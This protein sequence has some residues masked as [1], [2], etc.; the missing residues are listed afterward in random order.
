MQPWALQ[1]ADRFLHHI[2]TP[3][4]SK[5]LAEPCKGH[6]NTLQ[7]VAQSIVDSCPRPRSSDELDPII[8]QAYVSLVASSSS[9]ADPFQ[10]RR[11]YSDAS[12]LRCLVD[13]TSQ[14]LDEE[15]AM[16]CVAR[17]DHALIVAGAPG[18]GMQS[19]IRDLIS[20]TQAEYLP[21]E[22]F[23]Y[24]PK[25][26]VRPN[27][28]PSAPHTPILSTSSGTI[29]R[30]VDAPP[31]SVFRREVMIRPFIMTG[32][33]SDWPAMNDH[34]WH[35]IDYLRSVA[36]RGRVIPVEIGKDYRTDDWTQR[37]MPWDDFLDSLEKDTTH[38]QTILYMAQH[39][40]LSQFC[41]LRE[42]IVVPDYV[43]TA[44]QAPATYPLYRPPD[45]EEELALNAW[46]GPTGT[47]SP[48]HTDPFF[49]LYTQVVGRK[50]IWLAPPK[51]G[52][53][54]AMYPYP[55]PS[56]GCDTE[57][58]HNPAANSLAPSMTNTAQV[59]VFSDQ[60]KDKFPLFW[61][62]AVPEAL[63]A[64]LEPGDALAIPPGWWHAMRSEET[65]FS[66]SIW[67]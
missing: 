30:L 26:P 42:D 11:L 24:P 17:L 1:L 21:R 28:S 36:G 18:Q 66:L 27:R 37:I 51:A 32:F 55:P 67:F 33:A 63:S 13:L 10:W 35:S 9:T 39:N 22:P 25:L 47:T 48:A 16:S 53:T 19:L 62:D 6:V 57:H 49:N 8:E 60:N 45:N 43:F 65:S 44:P 12:V 58:I 40:L 41:G 52:V 59:D 7:N 2:L 14:A 56:V 15:S 4:Y 50:T 54:N 61:Q 23:K 5:E 20:K 29:P 34:P 31:L 64:T 3:S 38:S 46:L